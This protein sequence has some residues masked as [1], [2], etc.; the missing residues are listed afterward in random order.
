MRLKRKY[1]DST[2]SYAYTVVLFARDIREIVTLDK[3]LFAVSQ[4]SE[5]PVD[6]LHAL[7][8]IAKNQEERSRAEETSI[9][10]G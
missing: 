4:Q 5:D 1:Y 10:E 8:L 2:N 6:V 3:R 7:L 9:K